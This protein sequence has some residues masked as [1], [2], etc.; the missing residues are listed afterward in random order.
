MSSR[1][2]LASCT[3]IYLMFCSLWKNY[4]FCFYPEAIYNYRCKFS[5]KCVSTTY[6]FSAPTLFISWFIVCLFS[7]TLKYVASPKLSRI[8][9]QNISKEVFAFSPV[10]R[11]SFCVRRSYSSELVGFLNDSC[12]VASR[13]SKVLLA[14]S[15]TNT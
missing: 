8:C 9:M 10:K 13:S 15:V 14:K 4:S 6:N 12:K 5:Q 3:S 7:G 11:V 1:I 2:F